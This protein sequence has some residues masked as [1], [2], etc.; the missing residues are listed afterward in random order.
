MRVEDIKRT[1]SH[2]L[3]RKRKL[4]SVLKYFRLGLYLRMNKSKMFVHPYIHNT[5]LLVGKKSTSAMLQYLNGLNDFE[6][7]ALI[8]HFLSRDDIFVDVGANVPVAGGVV[9]GDMVGFPESGRRESATPIT[10]KRRLGLAA[11]SKACR[12]PL[13]IES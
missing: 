8:L 13:A 10:S 5:K 9:I 11:S 7:M 2:P 12:A 1:Y 3:N 6:E 4:L